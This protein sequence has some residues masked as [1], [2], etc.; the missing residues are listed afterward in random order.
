MSTRPRY[1]R[2]PFRVDHVP[3]KSRYELRD[4]HA[5]HCA[6]T[7]GEGGRGGWVGAQVLGTDPDVKSAGIDVGYTFDDEH[8]DHLRAPDVAVGD[9]PDAPGFVKGV[10]PLAVE[11]A[12]RGQDE[13]E[14]QAKIAE[15][16]AAGTRWIWVV[17]LMGPRRVEVYASDGT[18][19]VFG[20]GQVLRAEGILKNDVPV[21]ALY[22]RDAAM[23]ATFRNLLNRSGYASLDEVRDEGRDEGRAGELRRS[24]RL[25]CD[26]LAIE[27]TDARSAHVEA[28]DLAGLEALVASIK[29][30]RAW[31]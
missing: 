22:D 11:Y 7:G 30:A 20:P 27:W 13:T 26:L 19:K 24:V 9:I 15:F 3:P 14:L 8:G 1:E 25:A 16:L 31:P 5:I 6:P 17:R 10:P 28:L 21:E 29:E 4:G 23:K 12:S 18:V 2:G